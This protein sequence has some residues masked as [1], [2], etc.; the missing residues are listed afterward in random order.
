MFSLLSN[1]HVTEYP[2][3]DRKTT[4]LAEDME[5]DKNDKVVTEHLIKEE[6]EVTAKDIA[7][8][9]R[10]TTSMGSDGEL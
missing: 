4:P 10:D 2:S 1:E 9:A 3:T 6:A 5:S 7:A 8:D